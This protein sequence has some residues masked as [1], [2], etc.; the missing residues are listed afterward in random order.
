MTRPPAAVPRVRIRSLTA[1]GS[2]RQYAGACR[3]YT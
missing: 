1:E 3:G 2:Q